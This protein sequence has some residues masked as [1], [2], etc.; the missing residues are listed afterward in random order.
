MQTPKIR[1]K[2]LNPPA[3]VIFGKIKAALQSMRALP[4]GSE[5]AESVSAYKATEEYRAHQLEVEGLKARAEE[6]A[7]NLRRRII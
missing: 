6:Y 5:H 1:E 2:L 3:P 4:M 7:Q